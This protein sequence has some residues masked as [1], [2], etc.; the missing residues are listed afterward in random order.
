MAT[1]THQLCNLTN[2]ERIGRFRFKFPRMGKHVPKHTTRFLERSLKKAIWTNC[3]ASLAEQAINGYYRSPTDPLSGEQDFLKTDQPYHPIPRDYHY[4]RAL[5]VFEKLFRPRRRLQP[6]HFADLPH[7]PWT[8]NTSAEFPYSTSPYWR[9]YVRQKC[10]EG[11]IDSTTV[12]FH[13]LYNEI[14]EDNRW[15][16]HKIKEGQEPFWKDGEPV[17]FGFTFLHS[18]SHMRKTGEDPKIRAV[19]GVPKLLLMAE[20][21][22]IWN[23][24][25]EYQNRPLHEGP[26]LWGYET[27]RGGWKKLE[28]RLCKTKFNSI[29]SADWSGFDH[30]ALHE[31]IDDVHSIWRS[32]FDFDNGYEP[33]VDIE[34]DYARTGTDPQRLENLWRWMCH[35][36]KHTPIVAESGNIYRWRFNAIASG[37]QQTQL[38]DTAV[39]C[40]MKFTCL[41]ACG[42][43]IES[44]DFQALFQGDDSISVFPER[45]DFQRF[46]PLMRD[47]AE[48]R[49]NATLSVDKTTCGEWLDGIEVLS[50]QYRGGFAYRDPS[51]LLAHLLYPEHPRDEPRTMAACIGIATASMGVSREL[52]DTCLDQFNFL[53]SFGHEPDFSHKEFFWWP[54]TKTF[55]TYEETWLQNFDLRERTESDRQGLWPT[56]PRGRKG[57]RFLQP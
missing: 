49:F 33:S 29:L 26:L 18:R 56:I 19:F 47:E 35:S 32:W 41:S 22:F 44:K 53:A 8:L 23:L 2:L 3:S 13:N 34:H 50:Y 5:R 45:V 11:E 38:L 6:I 4:R 30:K 28:Q 21:M 57:F 37:F 31:L 42:I 14:F 7:Y 10:N 39:N 20:Q 12:N 40:I 17:P 54:K 16:I 51:Q 48:R 24:Q 15:K 25:R 27:F 46:L 9:E 36:I 55:P 43:N 1:L 52:Y